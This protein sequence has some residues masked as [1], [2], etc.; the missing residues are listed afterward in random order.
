V[1][2]VVV[3][4]WLPD[5]PG[6][7]GQ[8]ASRIGAV[9]GDVVGLEILERGAGRAID[10]LVVQLP[11]NDV[12]P[13]LVNEIGAVDGV[14]V[15]SVRAVDDDRVDP[16]LAALSLGA[17]VA[18]ADEERRL[19]V[20]LDGLQRV[21]DAAWAVAEQKGLV[22]SEVGDAPDAPWLLA[23]MAGSGHLDGSAT[24]SPSDIL[25]ARLPN[26]SMTIAA[27]RD[28]RPF[29]ESERVRMALLARIADSMI[30]V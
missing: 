20:L 15:E 6:A 18:E 26:S 9:R 3:R 21:G 27:G 30:R 28:G 13:L 24:D 5:R 8:V 19:T 22:I 23:F 4:V 16:G 11:S 2:T 14:S 12:I 7:L 10:E 1:L 29:H 17:T 25:L